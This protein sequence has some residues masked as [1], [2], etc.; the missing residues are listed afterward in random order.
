MRSCARLARDG[1][2]DI[3]SKATELAIVASEIQDGASQAETETDMCKSVL[4]L[5]MCERHHT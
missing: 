1:V 2:N 5:R 3:S 4:W